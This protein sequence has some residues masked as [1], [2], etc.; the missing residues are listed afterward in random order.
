MHGV[1]L[2]L[3]PAIASDLLRARIAHSLVQREGV[4]AYLRTGGQNVSS[5]L[6]EC[7]AH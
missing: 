3:A 7:T 5:G 6:C 1:V 4:K 2:S